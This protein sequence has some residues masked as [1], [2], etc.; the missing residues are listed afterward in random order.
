MSFYQNCCK[1]VGFGGKCMVALMNFGH[2]FVTKW[3][4]SHVLIQEDATSLD[5]GCGGGATVKKLLKK[6]TKGKVVGLDYSEVSV[7]TSKK[8]NQK[9]IEEGRCEIVQGDVM[10]LPFEKNTF[11]LVTAFETIYFW[12]D[13]NLACQQIHDVLKDGGTVLICNEYNKQ[14]KSNSKYVEIIEGMNI[15][16]TAEV[17]TL[18]QQTGFKDVLFDET[19]S[20]WMCVKATK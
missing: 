17:V 20:G 11:D 9:Y 6:C 8:V 19:K 13:L 5:V 10:D 4:L 1:P 7:E 15:Y 2:D 12:P 16:S 18:L 3:G 14:T